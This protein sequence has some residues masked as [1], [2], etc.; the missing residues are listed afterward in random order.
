MANV[1]DTNNTQGKLENQWE[2]LYEADIDDRDR[3]AIEQFV[4]L[5]RQNV[6]NCKPTTLIN[7]LSML[8][9]TSKRAGTPL[10]EMSMT[11]VRQFLGTL[12]APKSQDGYGLDPDGSGLRSYKRALRVFF[13]W[14]DDQEDFGSFEFADDIDL[15][16]GT[17]SRVNEEQLLDEEDITALKEAAR[18]QRDKAL[19]EFLADTAA[20]I[21]MASQLRVG[22]FTTWTPT[23]PITHRT[24]KG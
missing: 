4:R 22:T 16:S 20:R 18:N 8:R 12:T 23:G 6:E 14:L 2:M 9:N 5:H 10:V 7:D 21:S 13:N 15:P 1:N 11:D 3:D 24:R 17:S 19:I